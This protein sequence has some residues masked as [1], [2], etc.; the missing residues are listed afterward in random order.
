[1][2]TTKRIKY[3]ASEFTDAELEAALKLRFDRLIQKR[4]E[5][6]CYP[7]ILYNSVKGCCSKGVDIRSVS[8]KCRFSLKI[9]ENNIGQK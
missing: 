1:M 9:T 3:L 4:K 2:E 5:T 6:I 8:E 7:C